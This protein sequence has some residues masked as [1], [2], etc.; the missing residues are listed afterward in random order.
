MAILS[1]TVKSFMRGVT[2]VLVIFKRLNVHSL[3][4]F[5]GM[6]G[7][8]VLAI[9][10]FT[11]AIISPGYSLIENS[12]SSLALTSLGWMQTI[13][14][15][16]IGLLVEI[17]TA[18]LLYNVKKSRGF[19]LGIALLVF[20]GFAMLL[21][22]AFRTDPAGAEQTIEGRI[23]GLTATAAFWTFP[24]AILAMTPSI[25]N[26]PAWK[27]IFPYTIVT[28]VLAIALVITIGLLPDET[29]R[30]GLLER[31]LVANMII[32]VEVAA[33]KLLL[34]SLKKGQRVPAGEESPG[35]ETRVN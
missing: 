9:T 22:G 35:P 31:I 33:I 13:G 17:F 12:I 5:S 25:K 21:I 16:A 2:P 28:A 29:S 8:L 30:F 15:L 32:W 19:H 6:A 27:N 23:H 7:P 18:G 10:D 4:A 26:D 14:F 1:V 24:A 34:L 3:L 11:A 20:F